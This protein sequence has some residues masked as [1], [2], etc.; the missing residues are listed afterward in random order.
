M[1]YRV[2]TVL[3]VALCAGCASGL[4]DVQP[5]GLELPLPLPMHPGNPGNTVPTHGS[6]AAV[7]V[8]INGSAFYAKNAASTVAADSIN[9]IQGNENFAWAIYEVPNIATNYAPTNL[10]V[11][12]A[13]ADVEYFIALA[14]Y[15]MNQWEFMPVQTGIA[16]MPLG[17]FTDYASPGNSFY[18]AVLVTGAGLTH[19]RS[20]ITVEDT[21]ILPPPTGLTATAANESALLAWDQYPDPRA[22]EIRIYRSLD[23]GMAGAELDASVSPAVSEYTATELVND[24]TY[25]FSLKAYWSAE[26]SESGFSNIAIVT[27]EASATFQLSGIWPRLGNREDNRGSTTAIGPPNFDTFTSV[28]LAPGHET[29]DNRT[30]PAIDDAGN[31]FALSADGVLYKY[32]S[33]LSTKWWDFSAADHGTPGGDYICPPHSPVLDSAGNSYFIAAPYKSPGAVPY[34]FSVKPDGS[35]NW[36]FDAI[37]VSDDLSTPYPTP[38]IT[39]DGIVV[40]LVNNKQLL[41]GID[42]TGSEAWSYDFVESR[43]VHANPAI[44]ERGTIEMPVW[45]SGI[46]IDPRQHWISINAANGSFEEEYKGMG[47]PVNLFSGLPV[48]GGYHVYPQ[49]AK[50]L[51]LDAV[52][53]DL[54]DSID[55]VEALTSSPA[56]SLSGEYI[57][58]AHPPYGFSGRGDMRCYEVNTTIPIPTIEMTFIMQLSEG[59]LTSQPAV[60]G[61]NTIYMPDGQGWLYRITFDELQPIGPGNPQLTHSKQLMET[62][63]FYF[64]SFAIADDTA[65]IVSEENNLYCIWDPLD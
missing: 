57:F 32:S 56:R 29:V 5:S 64:S 16:D 53:G 45:F 22:D 31:V 42:N 13:Q 63:T 43:E 33:D 2:L 47:G 50:L 36:R 25:Y 40:A 15:S 24:T 34:I 9:L 30:T 6:S 59:S 41:V 1:L 62:D 58:Q 19:E 61:N 52:T 18:F 12:V 10:A 20:V 48:T 35:L 21:R 23:P 65:Y 17:S 38:N 3:L 37:S 60:D 49:Q 39:D 4:R 44:S 27:P 28:D 11:E 54:L 7:D 14:N 51:L 55:M 46:G 26:P 8:V